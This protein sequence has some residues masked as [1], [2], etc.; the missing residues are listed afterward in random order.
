MTQSGVVFCN[1]P[2]FASIDGYS[3]WGD[4]RSTKAEA[5]NSV[6]GSRSERNTVVFKPDLPHTSVRKKGPLYVLYVDPLKG[7]QIAKLVS[8]KSDGQGPFPGRPVRV[9]FEVK[10]AEVY[11]FRFKN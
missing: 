9:R 1:L 10:D 4:G 11:S 5:T 6:L 8:W 7:D 3:L 2:H